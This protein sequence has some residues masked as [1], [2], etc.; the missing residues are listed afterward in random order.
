MLTEFVRKAERRATEVTDRFDE[1]REHP[2]QVHLADFED[3]LQ[4][5]GVS[6]EQVKLV[7]YRAR[8][9]VASCNAALFGELSVSRVQTYLAE[10][11]E[12]GTSI[13]TSN[14]YLRAVKQFTRWLV[15]D[16]RAPDDPLAFIAMLN[17]A[18]DRRHDR[19]PFSEAEL[20]SI[21]NAAN[22]GPVVLKMKRPDRAMLYAVAAYTGLRASELASVTPAS[23]DIDGEPPTVTVQAGYS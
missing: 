19:R 12:A 11:R 15:R 10:L 1:H 23:F 8:R 21:V 13:Q 4:P 7:A 20:T 3:H 14:H 6:E 9:I 17:V 16:R 2:I 5:K 18:T 22:G